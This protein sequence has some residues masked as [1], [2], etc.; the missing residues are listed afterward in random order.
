MKWLNPFLDAIANSIDEDDF[1]AKSASFIRE[2]SGIPLVVMR[3][4]FHPHPFAIANRQWDR[5]DFEAWRNRFQ[6]FDKATQAFEEVQFDHCYYLFPTTE[7]NYKDALFLIYEN[8]MPEEINALIPLWHQFYTTIKES[9]LAKKNEENDHWAHIISQLTHDIQSLIQLTNQENAN[10]ELLNRRR[11]Q[12]KVN[13]QLLF[14]SRKQE[15][16]TTSV[17]V[18]E[19]IGS[20]LALIGLQLNDFKFR[21]DKSEQ[22]IE[23]DVELF[24]RAFN[25]IMQNA[26]F[27]VGEDCARV[28]IYVSVK[29]TESPLLDVHWLQIDIEDEGEGIQEEYLPFLKDAF[30]TTKKNKGAPGFGLT[31]A[32]AIIKA[33][34]GSLEIQSISGR[35]TTV[36]MTLP[37][38]VT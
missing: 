7:F 28:G 35:G 22:I 18:S 17:S 31:V 32:D 37:T 33:H 9:R 30:F 16:L 29:P 15:I 13:K 14:V 27:A 10:T 11:Y 4:C 23:V 3:Q 5:F 20:S 2:T 12:E 25:E 8:P 38:V 24:A 21:F 1:I 19:L 6:Y 36:R 34:H 26:L